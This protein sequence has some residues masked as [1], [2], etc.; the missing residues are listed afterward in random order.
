MPTDPIILIFNV[1]VTTNPLSFDDISDNNLRSKPL[2]PF[3]EWK[4][5]YD[6]TFLSSDPWF[7][8]EHC[9]WKVPS[10]RPF[11]LL[12]R[13]PC[14]QEYGALMEGYRQGTTEVRG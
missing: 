9:F 3:Y 7:P 11:V 4:W 14:T 13:V 6:G 5:K 10:L 12:V 2:K 1:Q 8:K